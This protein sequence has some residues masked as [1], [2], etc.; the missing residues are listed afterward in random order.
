MQSLDDDDEFFHVTCHIDQN[1]RNKIAHGEFIHLEK[2]LP[3]DRFGVNGMLSSS[4]QNE[5]WVELVSRDGH[6]YFKSWMF[7]NKLIF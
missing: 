1:T 4:A 5:N 7:A 2:L 3:R 6:T